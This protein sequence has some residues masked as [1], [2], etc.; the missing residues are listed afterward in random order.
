MRRPDLH[1][2][3]LVVGFIAATPLPGRREW[4]TVVAVQVRRSQHD[5][6]CQRV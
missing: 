1:T 6:P 2:V 4:G 3:R 5:L